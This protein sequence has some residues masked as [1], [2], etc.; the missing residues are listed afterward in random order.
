MLRALINLLPLF[1]I[2]HASTAKSSVTKWSVANLNETLK[3]LAATVRDFDN[4]IE[5]LNTTHKRMMTLIF[6]NTLKAEPKAQIIFNDALAAMNVVEETYE[7]AKNL[8]NNNSSENQNELNRRIL[9]G[10]LSAVNLNQLQW[11]IDA[12]HPL[13]RFKGDVAILSK[14]NFILFL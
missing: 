13:V 7:M 10:D 4:V 12:L 1:F 14:V 2:I 6:E 11:S 9:S 3:Y 8:M 5:P